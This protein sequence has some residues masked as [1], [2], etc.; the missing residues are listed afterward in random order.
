MEDAQHCD[1]CGEDRVVMDGITGMMVCDSCGFVKEDADFR[2]A[3]DFT[4]GE[5]GGTF[6][7]VHDAGAR[8]AGRYSGRVN[9][10]WVRTRGVG[11]YHDHKRA[12]AIK[13]LHQITSL[14]RLP[15]QR[16]GDVKFMVEKITKGEW[17]AGRWLDILI[18]A[19]VY[20]T[21]RQ[22]HLPLTIIEVA[23]VINGNVSELGRMYNRVLNFLDIKL[24]DVDLFIFLERAITTFPAFSDIDVEKTSRMMKHGRFLLQCAF[25]WFLTTGRHPLPIVAAILAFLAEVN[26]V[27]IGLEDLSKEL[28]VPAHTCKL[29]F[30]ELQESLVRV[31]QS[32]PWGKDITTKTVI[33]HAPFILKYMEVKSKSNPKEKEKVA[34]GTA[35]QKEKE[36]APTCKSAVHTLEFETAATGTSTASK[37]LDVRKR[38]S[39][40]EEKTR[41]RLHANITSD[42]QMTEEQHSQPILDMGGQVGANLNQ[43]EQPGLNVDDASEPKIS[44]KCLARVYDQ[45]SQEFALK[46]EKVLRTEEHSSKRQCK[47]IGHSQSYDQNMHC[48]YL[49]RFTLPHERITMQQIVDEQEKSDALPPSFVASLEARTRRREKINAAKLRINEVKE[50]MSK[51][52]DR[53][54]Q[55]NAQQ[56][57]SKIRLSSSLASL[58]KKCKRQRGNSGFDWEDSIIECL[59]LHEADE[60]QIED[61]HYKAMLDLHV[62]KSDENISD[63]E[64]QQYFR[65]KP[66]VAL[67]SFLYESE[68]VYPWINIQG[69]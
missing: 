43:Q 45:F 37:Y 36:K 65:T 33:R 8:G 35:N 14:L 17:G 11:N 9:G 13:K 42:S 10:R 21:V 56:G 44:A 68:P 58:S 63:E 22:N 4:T 5:G 3:W 59:L 15:T 29:R 25:Q 60:R 40:T 1:K 20:V 47:A 61:G 28:H 49:D 24:P 46:R 34:K 55:N 52:G 38:P 2:S 23:V 53:D 19:C 18:G 51:C 6:V 26:E 50:S 12:L 39:Q 32:L 30:K 66:E 48:R 7:S 27:K 16:V 31:G 67:L 62:F 69:I 64:L 54:G 41:C 57:E